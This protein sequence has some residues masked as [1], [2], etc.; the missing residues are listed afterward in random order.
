MGASKDTKT[1]DSTYSQSTQLG[2]GEKKVPAPKTPIPVEQSSE[3]AKGL[4]A[5]GLPPIVS[6]GRPVTYDDA[7]GTKTL[8]IRP[9]SEKPPISYEDPTWGEDIKLLGEATQKLNTWCRNLNQAFDEQAKRIF[10]LEQRLD[11]RF[12]KQPV[13][14]TSCGARS[15]QPKG[16]TR[17]RSCGG[18]LGPS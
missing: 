17:C 7:A 5:K 11:L 2:L 1:T 4:V 6:E 16:A 18:Q 3:V 12:G 15:L 13:N 14:C 9:N 10:K 8:E